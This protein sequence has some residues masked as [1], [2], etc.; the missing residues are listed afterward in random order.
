MTEE[1]SEE[2]DKRN[3]PKL[4]AKGSQAGSEKEEEN[5]G[6]VGK[7]DW[8]F[9][10]KKGYEKPSGTGADLR[11]KRKKESVEE[12]TSERK[13]DIAAEIAG[14]TTDES[15]EEETER[16]KS[17]PAPLEAEEKQ[18]GIMEERAEEPPSEIEKFEIRHGMPEVDGEPAERSYSG[19]FREELARLEEKLLE[20]GF[21]PEAP[22][23]SELVKD[24]KE[25]V[26]DLSDKVDGFSEEM[27]DI[28]E[29]ISLV[30]SRMDRLE[31]RKV[32]YEKVEEKLKELSALYDLLSSDVSP[33]IELGDLSKDSDKK[34]VG[35]HGTMNNLNHFN[36]GDHSEPFDEDVKRETTTPSDINERYDMEAMIDW[37]DFLYTKT[38][39]NILGALD[40]YQ[41]L[42]WIEDD[43]KKNIQTYMEG[44]KLDI[45]GESDEDRIIGEDGRVEK[46][47]GDWRLSPED[48]KESLRYIKAIKNGQKDKRG[49]E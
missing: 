4:K 12:I 10:G 21:E 33:F 2:K 48:H 38:S 9:D 40:Y 44:M 45:S 8:T 6:S 31:R 22:P 49:D 27:N 26:A 39:G 5:I 16:V 42:G 7:E 3:K 37:I 17:S 20:K 47:E 41:E 46:K 1:R 25:K 36:H 34:G 23:D 35:N 28:E 15:W 19:D 32:N 29:E 24:L 43:L 18:E 11:S 13:E 30:I 14:E